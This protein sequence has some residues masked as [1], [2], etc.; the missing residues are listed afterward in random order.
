VARTA[1]DLLFPL[2]SPRYA[3]PYRVVDQL[4]DYFVGFKEDTSVPTLLWQ[5]TLLA[6]AQHYKTELTLAQK[7][8]IHRWNIY[9]YRFR[10]RY[11]D[12]YI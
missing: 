7:V 12:M 10:F 6:F 11:I 9:I 4:V 2:P 5:H 3:L 1:A 8:W